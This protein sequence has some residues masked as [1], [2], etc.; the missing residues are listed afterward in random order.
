MPEAGSDREILPGH[1]RGLHLARVSVDQVA[2]EVLLMSLVDMHRAFDLV[3]RYGTEITGRDAV[4]ATTI[5][6]NGLT[7][8]IGTDSHFDI[9]EGIIRLGPQKAARLQA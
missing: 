6:N 7:H 1:Q 8:I 4:H 9:I 3:D 2:G 5:L